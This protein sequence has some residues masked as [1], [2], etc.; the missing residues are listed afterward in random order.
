[1]REITLSKLTRADLEE[2]MEWAGDPEVT[3]SLFWDHYPDLAS[4]EKFM[5]EIGEKHPW[6]M[7]IRVNGKA[8]GAISL[9][10]GK[11]KFAH[12]AELGYVM[13]RAEWGQGLASEAVKLTLARGFQELGIERIE[14]FVDPANVGSVRVLEKCGLEREAEFSRFLVHRGSVRDRY[15][16]VA[17]KEGRKK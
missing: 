6:L 10:P 8:R 9:D 15:L 12:K 16:Y 14:A 3:K 13:A 5:I 1:M 11:G 4:A 7:A 2:F 17:F